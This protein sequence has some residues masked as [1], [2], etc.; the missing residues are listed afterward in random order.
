MWRLGVIAWL[1]LGVVKTATAQEPANTP[2]PE[3]TPVPLVTFTPTPAEDSL[4][5]PTATATLTETGAAIPADTATPS[6][7]PTITPLW[8]TDTPTPT[9][10][11]TPLPACGDAQEPNDTPASGPVLAMD[12]AVGDLTLFPQGDVDMFQLWGKGGLYYQLTTQTGEGVDTRLRVYDPTGTLIAENDDYQIGSPTSQVKFQAPGDGWFAVAVDTRV[13]TDWGCRR[14][15]ITAIDIA[16]PTAT[17]TRTPGPPAT[18]TPQP[19][20]VP[21]SAQPDDYEPNYDFS[22]AANLG[23]G[24]RLALNFNPYPPGI[25]AIDNDFF[26]LYV[27][28]G[29]RLQ[30]ET[31][32]LAPGLDTNLI[33]YREDQS[34]IGGNDDC[35]PGELRSCLEW[36]PDYTGLVYLLVGPVGAIPEATSGTARAYT[37][38]VK[39]IVNQP[40]ATPAVSNPQGYG[41]SGGSQRNDSGSTAPGQLPWSVTPLP[42]T[43]TPTLLPPPTPSPTPTPVIYVRRLTTGPAIATPAPQQIILVDLTLYYDE[44]DNR[45][46]DPSE[47][48]IGVSVRA[49]DERTNQRLGQAFTD[50]NGH[51]QL[52]V[53]ASAT[54]RVSVPYLG[55]NQ[56]VR[57]P[58]ETVVIRLAPRRLPSIIP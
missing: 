48:L 29:Q 5:L 55:Y 43:A 53:S 40:A 16:P 24:Q 12:Q 27:K 38:S 45:A 46:P 36:A 10:T 4:L 19:T 28:A 58:G 9:V 30:I 44:N 26:R 49:V 47:G 51:V 32:D 33:L 42:P 7:T 14:Y 35:G 21:A 56:S 8:P 18:A 20:A 41:Y 23:V 1:M 13:P 57:P 37:L 54:V 50:Q 6:P 25:N 17:S 11:W 15:K 34:V 31:G 2:T 52:M 3:P 39:D 22:L